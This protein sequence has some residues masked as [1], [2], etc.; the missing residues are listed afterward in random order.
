M[1]NSHNEPP[2]PEEMDAV[3]KGMMKAWKAGSDYIVESK[4]LYF[5]CALPLIDANGAVRV[6]PGETKR[7]SDGREFMIDTYRGPNGKIVRIGYEI[8][9][10]FDKGSE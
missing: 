10:D 2:V 9:G 8:S 1:N 3:F 6:P 7:T 4:D 5:R